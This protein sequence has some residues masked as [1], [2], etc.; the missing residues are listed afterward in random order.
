[1]SNKCP[2]ISQYCYI[3]QQKKLFLH[4]KILKMF[5]KLKRTYLTISLLVGSLISSISTT[6]YAQANVEEIIQKSERISA[7]NVTQVKQLKDISPNDWSYEAIRV[8]TERHGCMQGLPN[9][10]FRG[11]RLI[12]RSEFAAGLNSCLWSAEKMLDR[13]SNVY[14]DKFIPGQTLAREIS[15]MS[16]FLNNKVQETNSRISTL[17]DNQF[18]TTTKLRGEI[19]FGLG[20]ILAGSTNERQTEIDR[21]PFLGSQATLEL[22]SSFTGEDELSIELE[23]ANLPDLADVTDTFQGELAF[24]GSNNNDLELDLIAY[25]FPVE[26]NLEIIIGATGLAADDIAETINFLEGDDGGDGAISDFG[27]LN[28]IYE[29]AEDA[30]IGIVYEIGETIE[31]SA[32][33]LAAAANE[34]TDGGI[35]NAPYGA[36]AQAI[37][38]PSDR[39]DLA[40]TYIHGRDL[41]DTDTGSDLANLQSFTEDEFGESVSTVSDSYGVEF[42]YELSDSIVIGGWGGLSTITTLSTLAGE[43]NRGT[44][45]IW[46]WAITLAFPDL[47]KEGNLGGIVIGAE[48]WVTSSSIDTL[49]EDDNV[50]LHL[51]AF[52]Q[53][54]LSDNLAITPGIVWITAPDNSDREDDL[55]IGAIRTTFAF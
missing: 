3:Y 48:P 8:L 50:S 23:A 42:S 36:I 28:P 15:Y 19:V 35:F 22:V 21:I 45:D 24:S 5:I 4:I 53:Y 55:V 1:M 49:G 32:G 10:S 31:L 46:N 52:Y 2:N 38:S 12:T 51:E 7:E 39:L 14:Y 16:D 54:R 26:D 41:S 11:N 30:G 34:P 37:I 6:V 20:S 25:T 9:R 40:F 29:T 13:H 17:E 18:S 47:G 33:Y 44:Q 27:G 43:I